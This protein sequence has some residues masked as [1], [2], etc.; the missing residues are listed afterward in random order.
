MTTSSSRPVQGTV[1]DLLIWMERDRAKPDGLGRRGVPR[2]RAASLRRP[3][4]PLE[5]RRDA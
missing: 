5:H 1:T 4:V 3:I 2:R